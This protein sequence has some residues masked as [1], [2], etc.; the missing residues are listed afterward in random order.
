MKWI[1]CFCESKNIG[2]WQYFTKSRNGFSH[3]YA[4][5]YDCEL[6]IW[7]KIEFTTSGFNFET[8]RGEK[9]T[10]LVLTMFSH[11]CIEIETDVKPIYMP[12]LMYCVSFIK[13]L[14]NIHKFWLLTPYQLY[15]ELLKRKGKVIFGLTELEESPYGKSI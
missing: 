7:R 3:V 2:M 13:H 14:C 4:V 6:D 1:I 5:S 12:R 11:K 10:Q 9:A 8:L 15:C